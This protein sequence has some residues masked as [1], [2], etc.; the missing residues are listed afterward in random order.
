MK[1][2]P[3]KQVHFFA[4]PEPSE[5]AEPEVKGGGEKKYSDEDVNEIINKR[6]AK[7]QSQQQKAIDEAVA[8]VEEQRKLDAMTNAERQKY[9]REALEKELNAL[10]AEK[11]HNLMS[12]NVRKMLSADNLTMPDELIDMLV[13]EN[14]EVT[15]ARVKAFSALYQ[16]AVN[17]GVREALKGSTPK[18]GATSYSTKEEILAIKDRGERLKAIEANIELFSNQLGGKK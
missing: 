9:E 11:A 3:M 17:E 8:K 12:T 2:N 6:F 14:A 15:T 5:P 7:W 18:K 10:K 13:S 4:E 1:L 16:K